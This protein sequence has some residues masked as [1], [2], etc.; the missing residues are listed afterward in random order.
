MA[1]I[2]YTV[3]ETAARLNMSEDEVL[4]LGESG[5]LTTYKDRDKIMFKVD[6]VNVFAGDEP[7]L[8]LGLDESGISLDGSGMLN[9]VSNNG[10]SGSQIPL[11]DSSEGI[12][13]VDDAMEASGSVSLA[14]D[15]GSGFG[16]ENP[17]DQSGISVFEIDD[18]DDGADAAEQTQITDTAALGFTSLDA[19]SS[20][21]GMLDLTRE[22]DDSQLGGSFGGFEDVAAPAAGAAVATSAL[23]ESTGTDTDTDT[24]PMMMVAGEKVEPMWSGLA[25]GAALGMIMLMVGAMGAAMASTLGSFPDLFGWATDLGMTTVLGIGAGVVVV[26][27]VLGAL[28]GKMVG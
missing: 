6:Q 23:F 24:A 11:A 27:A 5:Q 16:M 26:F 8:G 13:L 28:I 12:S 7:D 19:G 10:A 20:G 4:K 17:S 25:G 18:I 22:V 21:S 1:K 14:S 15:S 9:G 3:E 2:F